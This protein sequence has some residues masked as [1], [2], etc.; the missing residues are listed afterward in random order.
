MQTG[1]ASRTA[2]SVA[3]RRAAHQQADRPPVLDDPIAAQLVGSA[4]PRQWERALHPVAQDFRCFLAA[5]SR[6]AEDRLA[7]GVA[8]GIDQYILLGA[9]LDTFALRNPHPGLRVFE[10]DHPATQQWK[11]ELLATAGLT[12]PA[13]QTFLP[14]D[15][16]RQ[17]LAEG[18]A[19]SGFDPAR[20]A[21]VSWLGV[22]PYL[23]LE[24]FRA[25]AAAVGSLA[26][27]SG[28]CFDYCFPPEALTPA[29]QRIF[30][31]LS[32]RVAEAGEPFRLFFTPEQLTAEL[33]RAGFARIRQTSTAELNRLYFAARPDGLRLSL[34]EMGALAVAWR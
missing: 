6:F 21:F 33:E 11:R 29:R 14:V 27:G 32:A 28:L 17:S 18:L 10:V 15:F 9:G 2:F 20:P 30:A 34:R 16:E 26:A 31:R 19:S 3:L 12:E 5:R 24:A 7:E 13:S 8:H 25:T 4:T 23:T 22:V 1:K